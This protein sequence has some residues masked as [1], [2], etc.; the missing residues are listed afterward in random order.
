MSLENE[1]KF[2]YD[3][4]KYIILRENKAKWV[5]GTLTSVLG[6]IAYAFDNRQDLID[7]V[8]LSIPFEKVIDDRLSEWI[9][10]LKTCFT[11][12]N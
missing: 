10:I 4:D 8:D 2:L 5:E 11:E 1:I 7:L 3:G 12:F 9:E 6:F